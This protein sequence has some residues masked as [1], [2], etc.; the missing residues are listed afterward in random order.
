[1]QGFLMQVGDSVIDISGSDSGS[2]SDS[3]ISK[4]W[5]CCCV[6]DWNCGRCAR[7]RKSSQVKAVS[8]LVPGHESHPS[9]V[10]VLQRIRDSRALRCV[11]C[12]PRARA[13]MNAG[14]VLP[15]ISAFLSLRLM[16]YTI[17]RGDVYFFLHRR[18]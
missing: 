7:S 16:V 1:M 15:K 11:A 3:T 5:F 12:V 8:W 10:P 4:T 18:M 17:M 2:G 14:C 9:Q 13:C 6:A